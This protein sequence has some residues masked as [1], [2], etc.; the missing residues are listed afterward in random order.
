MLNYHIVTHLDIT[1]TISIISQF[2]NSLVKSIMKT[3]GKGLI[4]NIR[5]ILKLLGIL[6][7]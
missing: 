2:L 6:T 4:K 1:F 5:E 3:P 7:S